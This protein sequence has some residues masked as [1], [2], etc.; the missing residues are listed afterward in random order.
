[1]VLISCSMKNVHRKKTREFAGSLIVSC[2]TK[3]LESARGTLGVGCCIGYMP[4]TF[5]EMLISG[6]ER[7]A[8]ELVNS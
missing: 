6:G 2:S 3:S 5:R 4:V 1:M 7:L 8:P